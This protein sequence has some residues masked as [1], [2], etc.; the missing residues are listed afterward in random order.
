MKALKELS[1]DQY[2]F[3]TCMVCGIVGILAPWGGA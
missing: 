1:H 3:I 2:V